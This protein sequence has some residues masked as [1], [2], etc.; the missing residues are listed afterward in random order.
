MLDSSH[1][2]LKLIADLNSEFTQSKFQDAAR[3]S[4]YLQSNKSIH[5]SAGIRCKDSN[6]SC[7]HVLIPSAIECSQK[8]CQCLQWQCDPLWHLAEENRRVNKETKI[9]S[10]LDWISRWQGLLIEKEMLYCCEH[11][12]TYLD[13]FFSE[14]P[15]YFI[16]GATRMNSNNSARNR[17]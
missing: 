10:T 13:Q 11:F 17:N 2:D 14:I 8:K 7:L 15:D 12:H 9:L 3:N 1:A 5:S 6:E 16:N 4:S